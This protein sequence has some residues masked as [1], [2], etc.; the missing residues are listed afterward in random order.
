MYTVEQVSERRILLI[1][2]ESVVGGVV[3]TTEQMRRA[4]W[5]VFDAFAPRPDDQ[6]VIGCGYESVDVAGFDWN[7]PRRLVLG[8]NRR[9]ARLELLE[10]LT[11]ERIGERFGE[12]VV[13]SGAGIFAGEVSR[14][15]GTGID[16]SVASRKGACS[17]ALRMAASRTVYIRYESDPILEIA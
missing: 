1:D 9:G 17:P 2:I 13:A 6:I 5:S 7:G 16:V 10:V 11:S 12:V 15:A 4:Q 8:G 14:L 3:T